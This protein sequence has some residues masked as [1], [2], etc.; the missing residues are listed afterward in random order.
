MRL[1]VQ[2]GAI[3]VLLL[4]MGVL[5]PARGFSQTPHNAQDAPKETPL[6]MVEALHTAF[7]QHHARAVHTKGTMN[8]S[9]TPLLYESFTPCTAST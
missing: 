9:V 3:S 2:K 8:S 5:I 1:K 4:M 7:G 6:S